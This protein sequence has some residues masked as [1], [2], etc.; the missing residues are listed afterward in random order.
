MYCRNCGAQINDNAYVCIHCGVKVKEEL[1]LVRNK[2]IAAILALVFGTLGIHQFYLGYNG[3]G[4]AMLLITI[5]GSCIVIGPIITFF[6]SLIDAIRILMGTY[7]D[8][9]G[10]SLD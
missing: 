5:L 2:L 8:A 7:S 6:W 10:N 1:S 4:I 3:R 9:Q